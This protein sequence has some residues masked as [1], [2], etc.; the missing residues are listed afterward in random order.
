MSQ[1]YILYDSQ[2][3]WELDFILNDLL[4][5][6]NNK[7]VCMIDVNRNTNITDTMF[8][9]NIF[10]FSSN[11]TTYKTIKRLCEKI[12]PRVL[13]HLS[14]EWGIE[15]EYN[16][17]TTKNV[18]YIRQHN[19][20]QYKNQQFS[21]GIH[22]MP[23]GYMQDMLK[24]ALSTDI[25]IKPISQRQYTWSFIGNN[26]SDREHMLKTF[27]TELDRG[28]TYVSVNEHISPDTMYAIYQ[29]SIFVPVGR[30]NVSLDCF[31]VYEA[32]IAGALPVV[33]GLEDEINHVF[34]FNGARLPILYAKTWQEAAAK[35]NALLDN[36][37]KLLEMI[38][39]AVE[40]YKIKVF[41][42]QVKIRNAFEV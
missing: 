37:G 18:L 24:G 3:T 19:C 9:R 27:D 29:D 34:M 41:D 20:Y 8:D 12:K 13:I 40:W 31:R 30:G 17:L 21:D 35:C 15:P 28:K 32:I 1:I 5:L 6:V 39:R 33:V 16:S 42:L 23:L 36:E 2:A 14:D 4:C 38:E 22:Q 25:P 10:V 26:K 7:V 11:N